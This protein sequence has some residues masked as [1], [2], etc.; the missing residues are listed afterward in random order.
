MPRTTRRHFLLTS[1]ATA[2]SVAM[3]RPSI[4]AHAPS[5]K[6]RIGV[7]GV[8]GRGGANLNGVSHEHIAALC[9]VDERHLD[10]AMKRFPKAGRFVDFRKML[11]K[12]ELDAVAVASDFAVSA[13][14]VMAMF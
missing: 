14:V 13:G 11:D 6:L 9:D 4:L 1:A 5:D 12:T 2:A 7:V 10:G 3:I 8:A